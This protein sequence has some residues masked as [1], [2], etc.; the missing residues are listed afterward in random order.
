MPSIDQREAAKAVRVRR[1]RAEILGAAVELWQE[2]GYH[3][4]TTHQ[5]AERAGISVGL[6]YQYFGSKDDLLR[7]AIVDI[8]AE[9]RDRVPLA[10]AAAGPD[11]EARIRGG[12]TALVHVVDEKRHATVLSYRESK[13][14]SPQGRT[15]IKKLEIQTAE[16]F[17]RALLDGIAAGVFAD[18]D[19]DLVVHNLLLLAHGWALKHWRLREW[20]DLD[21]YTDRELSLL[22]RAIRAAPTPT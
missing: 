18:V 22:L 21:T 3:A 15:E 19:A 4:V 16:P 20:L 6:I 9:F 17:R 1:R 14:L 5:V 8:L 12:F 7:A 10:M 2:S 11:P 13:T